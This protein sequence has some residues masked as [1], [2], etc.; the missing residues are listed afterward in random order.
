M[1]KRFVGVRIAILLS[2]LLLASACTAQPPAPEPFT[3]GQ[4]Y[5]TLPAPHQRYNDQA[6]VEVVEVFSY[7][8]V[9]CAHFAPIA[10]ELARN[11][12]AGAELT[13]VPAPFSASWVPFARAFYAAKEMGV[14]DRTHMALFQ[15]KFDQHY[16]INSMDELADF[17]ARQGVDRTRFLQVATSAQITEQ[18]KSDLALIQK[19]QV[20]G[21]P[22][23]VINGKYRVAAVNSY[24]EMVAVT[25]WLVKREL[26]Q[27]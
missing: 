19:W 7:G 13:L 22:A 2:G 21:T 24:E 4:Q 18:M 12:P 20:D 6:K 3:E 26:A 5:V 25:Q 1:F 9:H 10:A 27:K 11:L 16:P 17:Y 14:L 8:C 23:I 15:A